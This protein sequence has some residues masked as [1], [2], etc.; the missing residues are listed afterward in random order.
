MI[1]RMDKL[2][3][4][5]GPNQQVELPEGAAIDDASTGPI[6][7]AADECTVGSSKVGV[8]MKTK[9]TPLSDL[10]DSALRTSK[11]ISDSLQQ[12]K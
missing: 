2:V 10:I 3:K 1:V 7:S 11:D 6:T 9:L 12:E 5:L 8:T 4:L